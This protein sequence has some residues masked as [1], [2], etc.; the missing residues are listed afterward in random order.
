MANIAVFCG[1][2]PVKE[3]YMDTAYEVGKLIA[4]RA[5][6]LVY[7]GGA[8]GLMGKVYEGASEGGGKIV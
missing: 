8:N 6:T 5:H 1:A 7:G 3:V 2:R 4:E